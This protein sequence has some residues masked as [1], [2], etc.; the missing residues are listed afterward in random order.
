[1]TEEKQDT[2]L[3]RPAEV[4]LNPWKHNPKCTN[5]DILLYIQMKSSKRK[6]AECSNL[7]I[8]RD[9]WKTISKSNKEW[10]DSP[11]VPLKLGLSEEDMK[12]LTVMDTMVIGHPKK[13]KEVV[14]SEDDE[15]VY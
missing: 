13:G 5:T 15:D 14:P 2:K 1:M 8:C 12:T 4:C 3:C 7:P 11:R 10:G 6:N 9:C